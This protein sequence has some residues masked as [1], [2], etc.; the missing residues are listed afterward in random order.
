M[1]AVAILFSALTLTSSIDREAIIR[2]VR[3]KQPE[4][5]KCYE[6]GLARDPKLQ[7][8]VVVKF[9]VETTGKVSSAED[10]GS[11]LPDTATVACVASVFRTMVFPAPY[12]KMT[13]SYPLMFVPS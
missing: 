4:M 7:G 2:V 6:A 1:R 11:D 13:I 8:R 12:L 3:K 5:R 10:A 9:V